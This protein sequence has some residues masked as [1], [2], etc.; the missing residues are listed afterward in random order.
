M[1][2]QGLQSSEN[3]PKL[4]A[5]KV[6]CLRKMGQMISLEFA[7]ASLKKNANNVDAYSEVGAVYLEQ[8]NLDKAFFFCNKRYQNGWVYAIFCLSWVKC[9]W[10]KA[11]NHLQNWLL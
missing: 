10:S 1:Y 11:K 5:R 7:Q 4:T 9:T 3:D 8:G 2:E 6:A